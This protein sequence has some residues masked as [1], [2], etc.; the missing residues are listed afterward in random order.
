M[1]GARRGIGQAI[2]SELALAGMSVLAADIDAEPGEGEADPAGATIIR[3]HVDVADERSVDSLRA[4]ARD[5]LGRVDLLVNSAATQSFS[6]ALELEV[7]EWD[8][9]MTVN[10]RGV[11]LCAKAFG[12]DMVANGCGLIVN[13]ASTS[14]KE[15]DANV[16]HYSA[17]K[18]AVIGFS[19]ALAKELARSGVRVNCICPGTVRTQMSLDYAAASGRSIE[20]VVSEFQLLP[21]PQE[22]S[23]I[24]RAVTFLALSPSI[25]GQA[26][27]IDGGSVFH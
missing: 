25:T 1:V 2:A 18:F 14:G 17:S 5:V 15:G 16:S 8:R 20:E 3:A 7:A 27:N 9:V 26:L 24:A 11:F 12:A 13:I 4:H 21:F 22:P 6:P 19:Q 10:A 23:E